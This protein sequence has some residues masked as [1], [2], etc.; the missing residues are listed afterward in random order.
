MLDGYL[1]ELVCD[2]VSIDLRSPMV[3]GGGDGVRIDA[4]G[5]AEVQ[6]LEG[7][8]WFRETVVV[9]LNFKHC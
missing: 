1:C 2:I 3:V 8:Y 7:K 6:C 9:T 4:Q 5:M